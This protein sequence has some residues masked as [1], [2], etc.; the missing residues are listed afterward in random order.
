MTL[1]KVNFVM[2]QY[3]L[4]SEFPVE[5]PRMGFVTNSKSQADWEIK[6]ARKVFC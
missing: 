4:M 2:A 6:S 3:G 1:G 5:L